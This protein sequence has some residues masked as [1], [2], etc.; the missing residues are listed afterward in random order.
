[1]TK[2]ESFAHLPQPN[3]AFFDIVPVRGEQNSYE[4][5]SHRKMFIEDQ[6]IGTLKDLTDD[7]M[8]EYISLLWIY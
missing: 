7:A 3:P 5:I 1:M 2:L 6:N 4:I 8:H